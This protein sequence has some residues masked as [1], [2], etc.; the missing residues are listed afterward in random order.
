MAQWRMIW[1]PE[2]DSLSTEEKLLFGAYQSLV[3]KGY[4][5]TTSRSIAECAG[6]NQGLIHHYFGSQENLFPRMIYRLHAR[7]HEIVESAKTLR[8]ALEI[9]C[10]LGTSSGALEADL[11]SMG[12]D[13]PTVRQAMLDTMACREKD[14]M[15]VFGFS[16]RED[17]IIFTGALRGMQIEMRLNPNLNRDACL[18]R[19]ADRMLGG[20]EALDKPMKWQRREPCQAKASAYS[21]PADCSGAV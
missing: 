4:H 15:E 17:V 3:E 6:V 10:E 19:L 21:A 16:D 9:L 13:M 7:A 12:R 20:A 18:N 5:G 2:L 11:C 8:E 14:V 1:P